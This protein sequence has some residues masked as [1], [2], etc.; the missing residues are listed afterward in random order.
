M[1]ERRSRNTGS[2]GD[3]RRRSG[4]SGKPGKPAPSRSSGRAS[5]GSSG[6][7]DKEKGAAPPR[8]RRDLTGAAAGLP[9]WVVDAL[10]RVTPAPRVG[11][12]LEA[13]GE[14]SDALNDGRFHAAVKHAERA[15]QLAPRDSTIRETLGIASYRVGDWATALS[16]LRA[17]RRMAGEMTHMPIE[18]D[19][20]RALRRHDEVADSW[21][22]LQRSDARPAVLKEGRVV[23]GSFLIDRGDA[24]QAYE[25]LNP[26]RLRA[27][28]FTEDL[29]VWYVAA[30]AAA[31]L[32]LGDEA[33][34]L[35]NAILESDPSFP[36]MDELEAAIASAGT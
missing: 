18:M 15:K 25:M 35:R 33:T 13:L 16:E 17:F 2:H 5:G 3:D 21:K 34:R 22:A 31:V 30:R 19:V 20:L 4:A 29:R 11:A 36:G 27:D 6:S 7:H 8:K 26:K 14:A 24:E 23:Y 1:A 32:G 9:R 10:A 12:A 28:P